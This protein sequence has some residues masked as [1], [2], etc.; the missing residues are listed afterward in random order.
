MMKAI[1]VFLFF[2]VMI[3]YSQNEFE[4]LYFV[5]IK[6]GISKRAISTIIEDDKG[7]KWLG[8]NG[9]GLYRYNGVQYKSYEYKY[10][11]KSSINSNL[12]YCTY[13]D[14]NNRLWVG[15]DEGLNLYNRNLDEFKTINLRKAFKPN[16]NE[17]IRVKCLVEDGLGNL[18]IGTTTYGYGLLKLSLKTLKV[19][20]TPTDFQLEDFT[21]NSTCKD[22]SGLIYIATS[23]G[24]LAY[25][26]NK[27]AFVEFNTG[28]H[29]QQFNLPIESLNI[30]TD[31]NLWLGTT[32][33]GMI[34][35]SKQS[36]KLFKIDYFP[37][38]DNR[39][40]SMI[41][42]KDDTI[43]CGTEND[44]LLILN[45]NGEVLRKFVYDKFDEN[46]LAS[47]SIWSIYI[48]K[49]ERIWLG[50]YN[51]GAGI[52]DKNHT[53][54]HQI[55][56]IINR[57]NSLEASSVTGIA[58]DSENNLWISMDGGGVNIYNLNTKRY[59]HINA[60]KNS[61]Y[62]G[63]KE[64]D[65]QTVFI[66]SKQNVWLGSWNHG[67]YVLKKGSNKFINYNIKN[68]N[69]AITSNRVLSFS[70]DSKG[71]IWFGTFSK[72]LHYYNSKE[73]KFIYC[74]SATFIKSGL[75][76]YDVRKVIVDSNDTIWVG[77][78][79]GLYRVSLSSYGYYIVESM[80]NKMAENINYHPGVHHI[81]SL[82]LS[83]KGNI[84]IGTDGGSLFSYNPQK[85]NF[86]W[87][88]DIG[89]LN[90]KSVCSIIE[91][92][93]NSLW[94]GGNS[95]IT[96][97]N[98]NNNKIEHFTQDDGLLSN[99][100][101]NN[102]VLKDQNG[103]LY[104]GNY[105]GLNYFDPNNIPRNKVAPSLQLTGFKLF[106]KDVAPKTENSPLDK[107]I[108]ETKEITLNY[109]QSVFTIEFIGINNTRPEK[110]QYAYYI[111]GFEKDWNYVGNNSSATYTNLEQ[112]KYVFKLKSANNDGVWNQIPLELKIIILP[113]WWKTNLAL[114]SYVLLFLAFLYG[115]S[116][117]MKKRLE[118]K[119]AV[120][121]ERDRR[122]NEEKLHNKKLQFFTNISHEFRT[123]LTLIKTPIEDI[124]NNKNLIIP[125]NIK[126]KHNVI[127]KNSDRL[128]RLID[129]LLD[130]R[131]LQLNKTLIQYQ[132]INISHKVNDLVSY[133]E[134]EAKHRKIELT[135]ETSSNQFEL[136]ADKSMLE[137]IIFNLLSN[138]FKVTSD[139]GKITVSVE[140]NRKQ[141]YLPLIS[142]KKTV[143]T[144]QIKIIDSG[145]GIKKE[146]LSKIFNR[147]YQVDNLNN[148]YY[149][150]TGIG[151]E[152]V[153]SFVEM[154]KGKIE[155]ESKLNK[156][157]CF[158]ITFPLGKD[159][160]SSDNIISLKKSY[161]STNFENNKKI[162]NIDDS[163]KTHE[164]KKNYTLL[165]VEDNVNLRNY[166]KS[167]L[168]Q[169]YKVLEAN[170]GKKGLELAIEKLPDIILTDVVMP[171]MD[172]LE[173]CKKIK[174]DIKISHI[175]LLML[176]AKS[177]VE[178][179]LEGINSG[180]DG[181]ISKPFNMNVLKSKLSQLI[182][183]R[184]LIFNKYYNGITKNSSLK[185]T[186]VDNEFIQNILEYVQNNINE[187]NLSVEF[188][189]KELF[190]SRSQLYRKIKTLTGLTVNEFIRNIR[191]EKAKELL[192]KGNNNINE[193]AFK[194]GFSSSTSYFSKCFKNYFG[195]L[196]SE[197]KK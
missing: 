109:N 70:E 83:K 148:T 141:T 12:I 176:T 66:D 184:Q 92:N 93:D 152:V 158:K 174:S 96:K 37:V 108:S 189:A 26:N 133:F 78:T 118:E 120:K 99:D 171:I 11:D 121:T 157:T 82:F 98:L 180:A 182:T 5:N 73:D 142:N 97:I 44:G 55:K 125:Q 15:T 134:E 166:L 62:K 53:K 91:G 105:L 124:I 10:N 159:H 54:F 113:P 41:N 27:V 47:N 58:M 127:Y 42:Y 72:G 162:P 65:I 89:N 4:N 197:I 23:I 193:V 191:L 123:P 104:F 111:E 64:N 146:D 196:P 28:S 167:E 25:D 33:T 187:T 186:L 77:T 60:S 168:N 94:L 71:N 140:K 6:E 63:L 110:N 103:I 132:K 192:E 115:V 34:K 2:T 56:S 88:N 102:A 130:F 7:F 90:E 79:Y 106:N 16:E 14:T 59:Q 173:M 181:Y 129:E 69:N 61:I 36:N 137:K 169:H 80:K 17:K 68:T 24:L 112:G 145:A 119:Q 107:V 149:G 45:N 179:R 30:D 150:S 38:S 81:L 35:I 20:K 76:D 188:L 101:N 9:S 164:E 155:V 151:L 1:F 154:H 85:N 195:Y 46:S 75:N 52:F 139:K 163:I 117:L 144:I 50:Y 143:D 161:L 31:N 114:F 48:D 95:G 183:S 84:W 165:I 100:F 3:C 136:W 178:D 128:S 13:I 126:D 29:L 67:L 194:V 175:P 39:I 49:S 170:N 86:T 40:M 87:Y 57:T 160:I 18:L 116:L 122:V 32:S 131:K 8:T 172:G 21:I 19:T 22:E 51:R 156:G 153:K 177:M 147:F 190:L 74:N 135:F 138:A 43:L 185:T